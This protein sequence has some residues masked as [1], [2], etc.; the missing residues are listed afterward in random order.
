MMKGHKTILTP[1]QQRWFVDNFPY[2]KNQDCALHLG[3]SL[4]TVVR[5]AR[6]LEL[7]KSREFMLMTQR[8]AANEARV[9]NR[10]NGNMGAINLLKYGEKYRFRKGETCIQRLGKEKEAERLRKAHA[11]RNETISRERMRINW[12]LPQRTNL[13]LVRQPKQWV[14]YRYTM[15]R[16]G[17][18]VSRAARE[19][20]YNE[21][22]D[23]SA[24]VE[25]G[26]Q[27]AGLIILEL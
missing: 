14:H 8:A 6:A 2:T 19:I 24:T 13:R 21:N 1:E 7:Q 26:A 9:M 12:G 27:A 17:Y 5:L 10:G 23:R 3:I 16:R 25:H 11:T 22:T 20:Y 4:R 18:I 15:K